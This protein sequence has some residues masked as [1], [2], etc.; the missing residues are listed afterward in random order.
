MAKELFAGQKNN[1]YRILISK[2]AISKKNLTPLLKE[3]QKALIISDDGVPTK[4][5]NKVISVSK[6]S[7]K[8]FKIILKHG[9]KAKSV[10]N[11]QKILNFLAE[12]N[13]DRT[14]LIIAVGGG[15]IERYFWLCCEFIPKR[16]SIYTDTD[17]TAFSSRFFCGRQDCN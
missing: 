2:G 5:L 1:R 16:H 4:I 10:Q 17:N 13:F 8:V 14:D 11:F 15:V 7:T 3:H 9:E 12:K 6:P